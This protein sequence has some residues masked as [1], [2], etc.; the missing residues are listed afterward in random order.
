MDSDGQNSYSILAVQGRQNIYRIG[1]SIDYCI[2]KSIFDEAVVLSCLGKENI[3][4]L[5][6]VNAIN[7]AK[8]EPNYTTNSA[9]SKKS[10]G[11]IWITLRRSFFEYSM[12]TVVKDA[13]Y[14]PNVVDNR[15]DGLILTE[16]KPK[17]LLR[18]MGLR[19]GDI[20]ISINETSMESFDNFLE[21]MIAVLKS[22]K[23][24]LQLKRRGRKRVIHYILR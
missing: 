7:T 9:S 6:E 8:I 15:I 4:R 5:G 18:R 16:I 10:N 21:E 22:D 13:S 12:K 19:N 24:L 20:L 14:K 11:A 23:M 2:L 17:S 3:L 1:D